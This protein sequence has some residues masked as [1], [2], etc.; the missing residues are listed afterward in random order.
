MFLK[1]SAMMLGYLNNPGATAEMIGEDGWLRTGDIGYRDQGKYYVID[2]KK[3]CHFTRRPTLVIVLG[4]LMGGSRTSSKSVGGK[5]H[6]LRSRRY[7]S[8]IPKSL[9]LQSSEYQI[10]EKWE[11]FLEPL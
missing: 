4:M 2:R 11:K 3:V 7:Y 8:H 6:Q 5:S 9:A 10:L 1:G